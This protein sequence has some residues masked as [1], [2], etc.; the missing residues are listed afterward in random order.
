[1]RASGEARVV[2]SEQDFIS[3]TDKVSFL[4]WPYNKE[5][6]CTF[7]IVIVVFSNILLYMLLVVVLYVNVKHIVLNCVI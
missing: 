2:I 4:N 7:L 1:M 6:T 5:F 3:L